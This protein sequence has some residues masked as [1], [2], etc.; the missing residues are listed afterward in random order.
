MNKKFIKQKIKICF[1]SLNSYHLLIEKNSSYVG[2]AEVQQIELARELKKR[3][4]EIS[5]ITYGNDNK[6]SEMKNGLEVISTY[7]KQDSNNLNF[8]KKMVIIWKKMKEVDADIYIHHTGSPGITTLFAKLLQKKIIKSISSNTEVTGESITGDNNLKSFLEK[9]AEWIDIK[10]SNVVISQ[11]N[12]QKSE[13][14][15][16]FKVES[17]LIPNAFHI[18]Q[19]VRNDQNADGLLWVG[20]IRSIKQP[21][22]F[23]EI[24]RH[25]PKNRFIM[26]GGEGEN[27]ALFQT[28][29]IAAEK[30][31]NLEFMGFV[32]HDKIFDYY[33]QAILLINTSKTEGFPNIYLEAWLLSIPVA[34][35][36]V[37]PDGIITK[38][39]LG[40]YSK[41]FEQMLLDVKRGLN[42]KILLETMGEN[43]RK[44]I[45]E[46]HDIVKITKQYEDLME[47]L[48]KK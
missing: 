24:A 26:I 6:Q 47:N 25:F 22:L 39:K 12:F 40:F 36:N 7:K 33:K 11:H 9:M 2:G 10:L 13:L 5:F 19:K 30:I 48:I 46:N 32:P 16:K 37:D 43:G 23:L 45:E 38:Y 4:Y 15:R 14:K 27:P 20:T 42:D 44:Y 31:S 8:L 21:Q 3:G 1:V 35:L 41:T 28:I 29:K 18:S 34:S 17:V